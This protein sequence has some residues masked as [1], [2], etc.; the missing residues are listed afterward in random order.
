MYDIKMHLRRA[1]QVVAVNRKENMDMN[2]YIWY[3]SNKIGFHESRIDD[4]ECN[5][6]ELMCT[7]EIIK[8]NVM[9]IARM[10]E[11]SDF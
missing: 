9:K 4:H 8:D 7:V 10:S 11:C 1:Y 6:M 5:L 2:S 3:I